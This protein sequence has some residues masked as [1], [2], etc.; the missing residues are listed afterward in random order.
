MN[1]KNEMEYILPSVM[2]LMFLTSR[3]RSPHVHLS[4]TKQPITTYASHNYKYSYFIHLSSFNSTG[5]T[6]IYQFRFWFWIRVFDF[7]AC[8]WVEG[9]VVSCSI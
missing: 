6:Y 5:K 9:Q 4:A 3:Y 1:L 7:G 8:A 2:S